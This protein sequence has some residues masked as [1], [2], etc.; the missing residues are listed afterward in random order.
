MPI[1][2]IKTR[3]AA[4]YCKYYRSSLQ[5]TKASRRPRTW[6]AQTATSETYFI[7]NFS[8]TPQSDL[9]VND[10]M[11][12]KDNELP[13][14]NQWYQCDHL[15]AS[16]VRVSPSTKLRMLREPCFCWPPC[17][18]LKNTKPA[19]G[20]APR[21]HSQQKLQ[22]PKTPCNLLL[23]GRT[24]GLENKTG[25]RWYIATFVLCPSAGMLRSKDTSYAFS[26]QGTVSC[27]ETLNINPIVRH[28]CSC[29]VNKPT[30]NMF[31]YHEATLLHVSGHD[32]YNYTIT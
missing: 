4:L 8:K 17:Y 14:N 23:T 22:K 29:M 2:E 3:W 25:Q 11:A 27:F 6:P 30:S 20:G 7:Y 5:Q 28:S 1:I 21:K 31:T 18:K 15:P 26:K 32:I 24:H 9:N 19:T 10:N 13:P 16:L 12:I